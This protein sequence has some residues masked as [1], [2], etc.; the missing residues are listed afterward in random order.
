MFAFLQ[1]ELYF[2]MRPWYQR[3]HSSIT[4]EFWKRSAR[5]FRSCWP[6]EELPAPPDPD[7]QTVARAPLP[8]PAPALP[9]RTARSGFVPGSLSLCCYSVRASP[10]MA[11]FCASVGL[12]QPCLALTSFGSWRR[13]LSFLAPLKDTVVQGIRSVLVSPR[14]QLPRSLPRIRAFALQC[15]SA[16]R[17]GVDRYLAQRG[18]G[19]STGLAVKCCPGAPSGRTRLSRV[20][21]VPPASASVLQDAN[22][23]R[24]PSLPTPRGGPA[25]LHPPVAQ[26]AR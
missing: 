26:L 14:R 17:L 6:L 11:V 15:T 24:S 21:S 18:F 1:L 19:S 2:S 22:A 13:S 7:F 25:S 16:R 10:L 12:P 23:T 5:Q 8:L 3:L 9:L 20:R 4:L